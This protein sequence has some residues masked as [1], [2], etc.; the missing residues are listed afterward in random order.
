MKSSLVGALAVIMLMGCG[1]SQ[2]QQNEST[3]VEAQS[4]DIV[5]AVLG[6]A[7]DAGKPQIGNPNDPAWSDPSL[8]RYATSLAVIDT[9]IGQRFLFEAT[10]DIRE[11][12]QWLDTH[13]PTGNAGQIDYVFIT[14]GHIGHYLGLA[15]LGKEAL[16]A[17][18]VPVQAGPRMSEVLLTSSPWVQLVKNGNIHPSYYTRSDDGSF[19]M[20]D[21]ASGQALRVAGLPI[22]QFL[23]VEFLEVPHRDEISETLG[24]KITG[25]AVN[26]SVL[27]IPDI[28][29]WEA[30]DAEGTRIEDVIAS[31]DIAYLDATFYSGDELPGRDMSKIPH[32]TI[33]HSMARFAGLPPEEKSK[34]RFIH[35]NHTNPA[36]DANSNAYKTIIDNGFNVAQQ[37][38]TYCLREAQ[39]DT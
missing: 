35:M 3:V 29:S 4:C 28:D 16:N 15:H 31:V 24:Y 18:G 14:H 32:P 37:G 1:N 12:I 22:E 5:L 10:P 26:R 27:F 33:T 2:P 30:W 38:E 23:S 13:Y 8:R 34:I 39:D 21:L 17:K 6:T 11:Q 36:H 25:R 19:P 9:V 20:W 7:Q